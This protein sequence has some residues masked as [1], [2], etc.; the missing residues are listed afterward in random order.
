MV[1]CPGHRDEQARAA[2]D[3]DQP[4]PVRDLA[5]ALVLDPA[6]GIADEPTSRRVGGDRG[7]APALPDSDLDG[8]RNDRTDD[9]YE[10][11]YERHPPAWGHRPRSAGLSS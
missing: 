4:A 2:D 7:S 9:E 11:E 3:R 1:V 8:P 10:A 5:I 6:L